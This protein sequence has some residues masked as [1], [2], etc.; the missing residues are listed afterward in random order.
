MQFRDLIRLSVYVFISSL[1][2]RDPLPPL[3]VLAI[4]R[5][6]LPHGKTHF[7]KILT[8]AVIKMLERLYDFHTI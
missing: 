4:S 7:Y 2:N 3:P 8:N 6:P 1:T 5:F